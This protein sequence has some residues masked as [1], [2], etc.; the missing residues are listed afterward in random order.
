M[1]NASIEG[2]ILGHR[3]IGE[4]DQI[5]FLYTKEFGK[6]KV[7][8]KGARRLTSK[9]TGHLETFNF[10]NG[11]IYFGPRNSILT[12]INTVKN[13]LKERK[14]FNTIHAALEISEL[15][16]NMLFENQ[17]IENLLP[18]LKKTIS[19]IA[20]Q[21]DSEKLFL[22]K[23]SF[24]IKFLDKLG[25]IPD[26]KNHYLEIENKYQKFFNYLKTGRIADIE[27][28]TLKKEEKNYIEQFT[29]ELLNAS[30]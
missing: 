12:E 3:N 24:I 20:I 10:I 27:K 17:E 13:F 2:V 23:K 5:I 28:I 1:K 14:S 11:Q 21:E 18:L 15:T 30:S 7:V 9:F 19:A 26:F 29:K 22:I 25:M 6:T 8:A 4:A 16:N